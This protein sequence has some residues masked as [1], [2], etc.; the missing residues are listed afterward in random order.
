MR[1]QLSA[2]AAVLAAAAMLA[3][4]C[5]HGTSSGPTQTT[6]TTPTGQVLVVKI[7]NIDAA[8][9]ATGLGSADII[10]VEPMEGGVTRLAAVFSSHL[11][12]TIGP[13]RSARETD[14]D[15]LAQFG[16]PTFAYSG[17]VPQIVQMLHS[18]PLSDVVINASQADV[19]AAYSRGPGAAPHNLF[20]RP[21]KLTIGTGPTPQSV[22]SFGAVPAGGT[23]ATDYPVRYP[24]AS[25]DFR[26]S[27][28]HWQVSLDGTP[29]TSTESGQLAAATV[30]VQKVATHPE[31]FT[32]D[33][34]GGV[35][36]IAQTVGTGA[37]T[38]L[39]DGQS[40]PV[41]WSRPNAQSGTTFTT[42]GG[43][44]VPLASGAVWVLLIP[45]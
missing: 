33:S 23:A 21:A 12:A 19:P 45:A 15:V 18:P 8:R 20:V 36:P 34:Q 2:I 27:A 35:T 30:I 39:R 29:F 37:A 9:P 11:P 6:P 41:T 32:E 42:A 40:F 1:P 44:Q 13:V 28:G 31:P 38:V 17:A 10:Y 26:W 4:A 3:A 22:L 16:K 24:A 43:Q 7:D 14:F 5:T 25:F